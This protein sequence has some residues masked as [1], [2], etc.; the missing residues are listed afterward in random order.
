MNAA[1]FIPTLHLAGLHW[2][3]PNV[4]DVGIHWAHLH[5]GGDP[6]ISVQRKVKGRTPGDI[7]Q[8]LRLKAILK[9]LLWWLAF[10]IL[11]TIPIVKYHGSICIM[12]SKQ[13]AKSVKS[14]LINIS[15][16]KSSADQMSFAESPEIQWLSGQ[17]EENSVKIW[18]VLIGAPFVVT[19]CRH[20][21]PPQQYHRSM[22]QKGNRFYLNSIT[23]ELQFINSIHLD[24]IHCFK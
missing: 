16:M 12:K 23:E 19:I 8:T 1:A 11:Q 4:T 18:G 6:R 7:M 17:E 9:N 15:V 14:F 24:G 2:D 20:R 3:S 22:S 21:H 5:P 13:N 10:E